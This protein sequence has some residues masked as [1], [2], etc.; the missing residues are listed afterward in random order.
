MIKGS[1][2]HLFFLIESI[3]KYLYMKKTA[4]HKF[5]ALQMCAVN[6]GK[7]WIYRIETELVQT[8]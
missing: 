7:L 3:S 8:V 4:H 6:T 1:T 2:K 5:L